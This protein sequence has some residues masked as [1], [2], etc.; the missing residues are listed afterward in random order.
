MEVE[1]VYM[2]NVYDE[3]GQYVEAREVGR[4]VYCVESVSDIVSEVVNALDVFGADFADLF[5]D[6]EYYDSV[7]R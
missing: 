5:V 7:V 3:F 1:V 2:K 6:G 4:E